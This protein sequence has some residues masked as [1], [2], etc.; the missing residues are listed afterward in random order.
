M[1]EHYTFK[2]I[3]NDDDQQGFLDVD[4]V[5]IDA[6]ADPIAVNFSYGSGAH[7]DASEYAYIILD[8]DF[9]T[10]T[11][12]ILDLVREVSVAEE[13]WTKDR[14]EEE[15]LSLGFSSSEF[16]ILETTESA[17]QEDA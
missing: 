10:V 8:H 3:K 11:K 6:E 15:L 7:V 13:L 12:I 16:T 4:A 5:I 9:L 2:L 17:E 14:L 1:R